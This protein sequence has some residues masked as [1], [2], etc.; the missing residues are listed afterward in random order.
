MRRNLARL[1]SLTTLVAGL[2]VV[3]AGPSVA[4]G[5]AASSNAV[6]SSAS[7]SLVTTA[8]GVSATHATASHG[9]LVVTGP[10]GVTPF[11]IWCC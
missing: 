1:V 6:S 3:A 10:T 9:N 8:G 2:T 5:A 11:E 7:H 4:A